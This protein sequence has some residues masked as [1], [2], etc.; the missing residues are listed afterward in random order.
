MNRNQAAE[1]IR[2]LANGVDPLTGEIFPDESPYQRPQVIRA[3]FLA[4]AAVERVPK[5]VKAQRQLPENAGKRWGKAEDEELARQFDSGA[6]VREI[7][8]QH[9]RTDGAIRSRLVRIGKITDWS[10]AN[11]ALAAI[12]ERDAGNAT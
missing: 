5:E 7:T 6:T 8:R 3:L 4:L 2:A 11:S 1:I 12:R 10:L 9:K